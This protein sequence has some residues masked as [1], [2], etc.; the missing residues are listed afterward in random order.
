VRLTP[1]VLIY[2]RDKNKPIMY[3]GVHDHPSLSAF[4]AD[5][6]DRNGFKKGVHLQN[7]PKRP[8]ITREYP[9]LKKQDAISYHESSNILDRVKDDQ[10]TNPAPY[11]RG[12]AYGRNSAI[13][14]R[15]S[16]R[17]GGG[18]QRRYGGLYG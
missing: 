10:S 4:I 3:G 8:P 9:K 14:N 5:Y 17:Y 6:C 1:A 16:N 2:G 12:R 7:R 11:Q 15:S 18:Y 13:L